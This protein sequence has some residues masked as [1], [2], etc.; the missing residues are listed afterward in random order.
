M[1][2][3]HDIIAEQYLEVISGDDGGWFVNLVIESL[4][5]FINCGE[6]SLVY[7]LGTFRT[8]DDADEFADSFR[9]LYDKTIFKYEL[10]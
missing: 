7:M 3:R 2:K 4:P 8:M 1:K 6:H 10:M 9:Y 5:H